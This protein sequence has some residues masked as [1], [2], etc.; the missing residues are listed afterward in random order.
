MYPK[1][2]GEKNMKT[3]TEKKTDRRHLSREDRIVIQGMIQKG[4]S[5]K[6]MAD[7]LH[8]SVSTISKELKRNHIVKPG[9]KGGI[10]ECL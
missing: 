7:Y 1:N 5:L 2:E 4:W 3:I 10:R 9:E 8:A 6:T